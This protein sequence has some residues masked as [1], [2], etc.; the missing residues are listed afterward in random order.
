MVWDSTTEYGVA[1]NVGRW[2]AGEW[3]H[4]VATWE[5]NTI[6]LYVDGQQQDSSDTAGTPD[7]L[8]DSM[9][10]GS[11]AW[12]GQQANAGIDEFRI[13]DIRRIG[14]SD[15]CSYR[16]LVADSGNHR[17][18][19]FD[20]EGNFVGTYGGPGSGPSEF[21]NPQGLA[22]DNSGHIV[23]AD[24][25]NNR[26]QVLE[27]DGTS[28]GFIRVI[29]AGF[30]GPTSVATYG[31]DHIIAADT[32]NNK[33]KVLDTEGNLLAEYESPNDDYTGVFNHPH[34]V[35]ADRS[36][37]IVV[38]DT[39]NRRVVTILDALPV[40]PLTQVVITGPT[41]G[42]VQTDYPFIATVSPVTATQPITYVWRTSERSPVTRTSG[43]SDA[44]TYTWTT[45]GTRTITIT[46]ANATSTVTGTHV[47]SIV[48]G[49]RLYLPLVLRCHP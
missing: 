26:L 42:F 25:G 30:N 46:A 45:V 9:Y 31:S 3:H 12:H 4:V 22:T 5:G 39:G 20:L 47:I 29:T 10:I 48:P 24:S 43:T 27:F 37:H 8:A 44:V 23:V 6:A 7:T 2:R 17:I 13:S 36:A 34:G 49:R 35:A 40:W 16:I 18:Q 15:T 19:A 11:S 14:N 41:L 33:T 1:Y 28:F 32:G 38:A 21:S